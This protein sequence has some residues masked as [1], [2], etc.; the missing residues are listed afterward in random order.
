MKLTIDA[1][2]VVPCE[3]CAPETT[4]GYYVTA[5]LPGKGETSEYANFCPMCG[6]RLPEANQN[7]TL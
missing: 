2:P 6:R 4:P 1:V 5:E 7:G 3:W